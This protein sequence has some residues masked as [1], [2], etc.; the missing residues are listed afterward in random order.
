MIRRDDQER[1]TANNTELDANISAGVCAA[2]QPGMPFQQQLHARHLPNTESQTRREIY[3]FTY[4]YFV[5]MVTKAVYSEYS[6][7]VYHD[8]IIIQVILVI[9][10]LDSALR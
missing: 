10:N 5:I 8:H 3:T 9:P 7:N 4:A 1:S 6:L 2:R